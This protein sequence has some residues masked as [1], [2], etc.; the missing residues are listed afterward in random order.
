MTKLTL[1]PPPEPKLVTCSLPGCKAEFVP[2]RPHQK[3]CTPAHATKA[4]WLRF[5]AKGKL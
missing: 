2:S 4:R 5:R 1:P 3:Y